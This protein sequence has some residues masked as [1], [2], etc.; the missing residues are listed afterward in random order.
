L[1]YKLRQKK[2]FTF[3]TAT[4]AMVPA[5]VTVHF[6][7]GGETEH[8]SVSVA[9]PA[10]APAVCS[11]ILAARPDVQKM[12]NDTYVGFELCISDPAV[13]GGSGR[14]FPEAGLHS[15]PGVVRLVT[16]LSSAGCHQL[17]VFFA[18]LGCH[19]RGVSDGYMDTILAVNNWRV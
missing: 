15:L 6:K 3:A 14:P 5:P 9:H 13:E 1:S 18:I 16:W 17:D 11:A 12:L 19:S 8:K 4:M 7:F 10:T 2:L